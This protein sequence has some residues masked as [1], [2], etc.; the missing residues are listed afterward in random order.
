MRTKR[1]FP[2]F[3]LVELLVVITIIGILIALTMPALNSS[4]E[5]ARGAQCASNLHQI[6]IGVRHY[7]ER[8]GKS[9]DSGTVI[10]GFG[11]YLEGQQAVNRCPSSGSLVA[12]ASGSTMSGSYGVNMCL[13]RMDTSDANKIIVTDS[14]VGILQ[15]EG[16]SQQE[17]NQAIAPRHNGMVNVLYFDGHVLSQTP[18]TI[19]PYA[20]VTTGGTLS[21]TGSGS[22]SQNTI[23][24][25][26][27]MWRPFA[28]ACT[29]CGGGLLGTYYSGNGNEWGNNP[30]TRVDP[31]LTYPFGGNGLPYNGPCPDSTSY[32]PWTA[33]WTGQIKAEKN[34]SYTIWARVDNE[35]WVSVAGQQILHR[36]TGG[37]E[38]QNWQASD[39]AVPMQAGQWVDIEVRYQQ[40]D[41]G[42][43]GH[44]SI[45]WSSP[46]TPQGDIPACDLKPTGSN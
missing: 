20:L 37:G 21:S 6:G 40:W 18:A 45:Q 24:V 8:W 29:I 4:R 10:S 46:S 17:W 15:Y 11:Q 3:T 35:V 27:E 31:C 34:E 7:I 39:N 13:H 38:C 14:T 26:A 16:I 22:S 2:A 9:P 5:T 44:V 36:T 28:G 42:S 32:C 41:W 33:T 25:L 23:D 19:N 30:Y 43:P 12:S 1:S